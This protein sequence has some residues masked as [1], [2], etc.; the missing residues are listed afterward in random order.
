MRI[1]I[2]VNKKTILQR[3]RIFLFQTN[4]RMSKKERVY[5]KTNFCIRLFSFVRIR[6]GGAYTHAFVSCSRTNHMTKL[7][8]MRKREFLVEYF[9]QLTVC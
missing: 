9:N 4:N 3:K 6:R 8:G 2:Y 5:A 7:I 1:Y